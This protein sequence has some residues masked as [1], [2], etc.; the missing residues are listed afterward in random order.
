MAFLPEIDVSGK[1]SFIFRFSSTIRK[2]SLTTNLR[3][4]Y[5][6]NNG[7]NIVGNNVLINATQLVDLFP[8][9]TAEL[10]KINSIHNCSAGDLFWAW[11]FDYEF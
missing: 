11:V 6:S 7:A 8:D 3:V 5:Q 9:W 10:L 4:G 1:D 2:F